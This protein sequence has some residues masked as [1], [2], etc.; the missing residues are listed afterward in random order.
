MKMKLLATVVMALALCST[1]A[2][3]NVNIIVAP[4]V[5]V[6]PVV[7]LAPV[8]QCEEN[9]NAI[10]QNEQTELNNCSIMYMNNPAMNNACQQN[11]L[12]QTNLELYNNEQCR[13]YYLQFGVVIIPGHEHHHRFYPHPEHF[14]HHHDGGD[15]HWHR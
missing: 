9:Y 4:V 3:A 7:P 10:I 14:P 8:N 12:S 13:D 5:P 2:N 11:V 1:Q 6:V 15:H